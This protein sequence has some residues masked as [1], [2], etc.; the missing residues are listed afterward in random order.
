MK[1]VT[2]AIIFLSQAIWSYA[3]QAQTDITLTYE[4][5]INAPQN[6]NISKAFN[7]ASYTV[8]LKGGESRT[9]MR[10]SLGTETSVYN[11]RTG[12]GIILKEYSGQK[13]MI[14]L[15]KE[16]WKQKNQLFHTLNFIPGNE[17]SKVGNFMVRPAE[18]NLDGQPFRLY[19]SNSPILPN[20]EYNN[21]FG[22]LKGVPVKYDL[23]SG[24]LTFTYTLT[25]ISYDIIPAAKFE[26]P[27]SGFRVM[28]YDENQ[29]MKQG[30]Q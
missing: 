9:E 24:N 26:F 7:G 2:F 3:Q 4:I 10:S 16:N 30:A 23:K 22:K 6:E 13:L 18:A 29:Q 17:E 20:V 27:K 8:Y 28:S 14:T 12:R 1:Y 15:T 11:N 21:A 5:S 25:T 19:F